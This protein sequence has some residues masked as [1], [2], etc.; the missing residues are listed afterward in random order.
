[1]AL[2][3]EKNYTIEDIYALPEGQRAELIDGRIYMMVPPST[4]HQQLVS[5]FTITIGSYIRSKGGN[6][7]V[8]PAPF[9]VFLNEDDR[10]YV[11]PDISVICNKNKLDERGCNGAPDWII[12][13]TSPSNTENDY[14]IKLFKYRTAGVREYWIVNPRTKTVTVYDF[15]KEEHSNQYNFDDTIPVCIYEDFSINIADL[16]S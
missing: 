13:I 14:N 4:K 7:S 3:Q 5:E 15:E 8:F 1:M 2:P 9:A 10:N 11:E 6:C 12:E 16:L